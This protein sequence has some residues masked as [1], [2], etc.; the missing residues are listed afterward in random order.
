[1]RN[2]RKKEASETTSMVETSDSEVICMPKKDYSDY[3][4]SYTQPTGYTIVHTR[5]YVV[6]MW[7]YS[8]V[9]SVVG[10]GGP[11]ITNWLV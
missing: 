5:G 6:C 10:R 4:Y 9:I 2:K 3:S 11:K 7:T 1:M 8:N